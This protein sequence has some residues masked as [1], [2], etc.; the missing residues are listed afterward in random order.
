MENILFKIARICSS[1]FRCNY[2]KNIKHVLH[3]LF[4]FWRLDQILN[5]LKENILVIANVFPKL[6]TEKNLSRILSNNR[7]SRL[8]FDSQHVTESQ[9]LVKSSWERFYHVFSSKPGNL[10]RKMSALVLGEILGVFVNTLAADAKCHVQDC[11]NLQLPI[12]IQL[13]EKQ[14]TF[15]EFLVPFLESTSTFKQTQ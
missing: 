9:I 3:F 10:I 8:R 7:R 2:L 1:Q 11:E 12:Q 15:S 4:D 5:I 14:K 13:S 6:Q